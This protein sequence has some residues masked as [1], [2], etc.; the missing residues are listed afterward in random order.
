MKSRKKAAYKKKKRLK[1]VSDQKR[2]KNKVKGDRGAIWK[3]G[4]EE[5]K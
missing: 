3:E 2:K 4:K 1:N 5:C